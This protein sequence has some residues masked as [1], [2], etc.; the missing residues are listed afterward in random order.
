MKD[1]IFGLI[2]GLIIGASVTAWAALPMSRADREYGKFVE[3]A[4]GNITVRILF[5]GS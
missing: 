5:S 1:K 3:D 4:S 2:I